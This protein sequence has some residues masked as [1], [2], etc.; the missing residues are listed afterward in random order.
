MVCSMIS[1]LLHEGTGKVLINIVE[2]QLLY[3]L[4]HSSIYVPAEFE[5]ALLKGSS[6]LPQMVSI[7]YIS[8]LGLKRTRTR[9]MVEIRSVLVPKL[10]CLQA[11]SIQRQ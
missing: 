10:H 8:F 11:G 5:V 4:I 3:A 1:R 6:H 9:R 7:R 2:V